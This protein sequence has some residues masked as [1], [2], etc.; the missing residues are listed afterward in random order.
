MA[1]KDPG[2]DVSGD[3]NPDK[4]GAVEVTRD[5]AISET[6]WDADA[7]NYKFGDM[8]AA[9][10]EYGT[11][12]TA[13]DERAK[14]IPGKAEEYKFD[15]PADFKMPDGK[16]WVADPKDPMVS[17][18]A[19]LAHELKL[20]QPELQKIALFKAN[21]DK[22]EIERQATFMADQTKALGEKAAERRKAITT[23]M[24]PNLSKDQAAIASTLLDYEHGVTFMEKIMDMVKGAQLRANSGHQPDPHA[25]RKEQADRIGKEP[26][27]RKLLD[28]A[29]AE[30]RK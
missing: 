21:L 8:G 29:N 2:A 19:A 22:A 10:T 13:A 27:G 18:F 28:Q 23:W 6:Y 30:A 17:G 26:M 7:K 5:E 25:D 15:L 20:T 1:V 3:S 9:L 11:M 16:Q 4:G 14:L 24:G 12:K